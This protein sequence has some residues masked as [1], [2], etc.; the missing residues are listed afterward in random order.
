MATYLASDGEGSVKAVNVTDRDIENVA[1][2]NLPANRE[3]TRMVVRALLA[4]KGVTLDRILDAY[5]DGLSSSSKWGPNDKL[6]MLAADKLLEITG[7]TGKTDEQARVTINLPHVDTSSLTDEELRIEAQRRMLA[8]Q[9]GVS[10]EDIPV[11]RA[12]QGMVQ[13]Y[14]SEHDSPLVLIT[15]SGNDDDSLSV[16][17]SEGN[18]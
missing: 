2:G 5:V 3:D 4:R 8:R 6:R 16:R 12:P 7:V 9:K 13:A 18:E 14:G 1:M 11:P 10:L 17:E 15:A